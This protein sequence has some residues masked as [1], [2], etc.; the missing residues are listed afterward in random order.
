VVHQVVVGG[1]RAKAVVYGMV[2]GPFLFL[3]LCGP[4][5]FDMSSLLLYYF[6]KVLTGIHGVGK[7]H[8]GIVQCFKISGRY[9]E[10]EWTY[11]QVFSI[12]QVIGCLCRPC[13]G[14]WLLQIAEQP[15]YPGFAD[16]H[17]VYVEEDEVIYPGFC[18]ADMVEKITMV[19]ILPHYLVHS[20]AKVTEYGFLITRYTRIY[21]AF[22]EGEYFVAGLLFSHWLIVFGSCGWVE[23]V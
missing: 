23:G 15:A 16:R 12:A 20:L 14:A 19:K 17:T 1:A 7:P 11:V 13:D 22:V 4:P 21:I 9:A 6:R 5:V 18:A 2:K 3:Y 10:E 8:I